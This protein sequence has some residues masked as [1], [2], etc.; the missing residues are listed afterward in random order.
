MARHSPK[1]AFAGLGAMGYGM[2]AHLVK[3]GFPVT[4]FDVYQPALDRFLKEGNG[5]SAAK[6]PKEAVR[7][8]DFFICM[9]ANSVQATPL[10]FDGGMG[11]VGALKENATVIMCSTVAPAYIDEIQSR[12]KK[13]GRPDIRLID[14][15]VSGGAGRAADGTL[16]IFA[17]GAKDDVEHARAVLQCMSGKLY[18][19]PG[20]LGGG[21]KA[22]LIHQIFAGIHI[23][24]ANEAMGLAAVAGMDTREVFERLRGSEACSWMF[25]NR[26]PPMLD[27]GLGRYSAMTIIAKDVGII[28]QTSRTH[29]FPLPLLS[30]AEQLYLSALTNGWGAEDDCVLVRLYLPPSQ[31]DLVATQSG[32]PSKSST[33]ESSR[34]IHNVTW[35]TI[36][37]IMIAVHIAAVTE[38]MGFCEYLGIDVA[39]MYDIVSNAA[40]NSRVFEQS[41]KRMGKKGWRVDGLEEA[42]QI[43]QRLVS[44]I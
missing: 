17:S 33:K 21:S 18:E 8:V 7:D 6:T 20:G 28:T 3:S 4:G 12:S 27:A 22:K 10:F 31:A 34:P 26:V 15:P 23:A 25:E 35:E 13:V 11:A 19:I 29:K 43:V 39:L 44:A 24:M 42:E 32:H 9:V 5:A 30:T 38:A 1:I 40:G 16:S 36:R 14:S 37:D 41:F 2:A